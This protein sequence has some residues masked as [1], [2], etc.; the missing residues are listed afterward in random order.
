[1]R[2]IDWA[3]GVKPSR[4]PYDMYVPMASAALVVTAAVLA[5]AVRR[6]FLAAVLADP[7]RV[8]GSIMEKRH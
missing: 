7:E 4:Y 8:S 6:R 1:M 2:D 5:E 3:S